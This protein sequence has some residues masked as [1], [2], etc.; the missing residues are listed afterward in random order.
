MQHSARKVAALACAA[1][2]I[3]AQVAAQESVSYRLTFPA[4]EHHWLAVEATFASLPPGTLQLRM[5]RSSPGRYALHEFAKNIIDVWIRD[6]KGRPL[7]ATRSNLHGWDVAGHDGTVVVSYRIYGDRVDG[8]YLAVDTTHAHINIPATLIWARGLEMRPARV[9]FVPPT[10]RQWRVATQL[11]PTPD[12]NSFTAPNLHYLMDSPTEFSAYT[13]RTF[14]VAEGTNGGGPTFRIALHHDGSDADADAYA[15]DTE[16]IVRETKAVFGEFPRYENNTYTFLA[17]YLPWASGDGMEHRNSTV[18][19]SSGALR[20]AGQ[21]GGLLGTVAHEYFHSWNMERIRAKAIE[22]FNFEDANVSGEL[23]LGEG[24]TSYYDD[25]ILYRS[26]LSS[27]DQA[28]ASFGGNINAVMASPARQVRSAEEMSRLAPFTDAAVS[29]DR[30]YWPNTFISYY[31]W[32]AA[33]GIGLDLT[34]R[35]RSNG[36]VSLDDFMRALWAEFGR[37]GQKEPGM[38]ATPYTMQDLKNTLAKV[39]GDGGFADDF[40]ARFVQ[41][42]ELVDYA[43][44]LSRAGFVAR[45]RTAG[46]AWFAGSETLSFSGAGG[47]VG[48]VVNLESALYKAGVDQDDVIASLAGT[49]LTSQEALESVLR[50]HK[51]GDTVPLRVVHRGGEAANATITLEEN[52]WM[53][54]VP[55]EKSGGTLSPEQKQFRDA[56]LGSKVEAR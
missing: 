21:R 33:L 51:P 42:H 18:L 54:I 8:T 56:W 24:F 48:A 12:P 36:S 45:T 23:W 55:I 40:F 4:P 14:T 9:T 39:S 16:K 27:L 53:E 52:R 41:G 28:L 11:Y 49:P 34:L 17:D 29:N 22:P 32:G 30:T 37:P 44:L 6:G 13:L 20:D 25:L 19:S 50:R 2:V 3:A 7:A 47:H 5:S 1:V 26:G 38:V 46:R 43:R 15:R 10:G 31:T 35:D